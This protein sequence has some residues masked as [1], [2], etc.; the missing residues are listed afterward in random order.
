M[1]ILALPAIFILFVLISWKGEESLRPA[2]LLGAVMWGF[3]VTVMVESLSLFGLLTRVGVAA[4][5]WSVVAVSLLLLFTRS[6]G[7][8]PDSLHAAPWGV[9][10][11]RAWTGLLAGLGLV[12]VA[13]GITA[14]VA[15]PNN[16]DSMTYHMSRVVH[17]IQNQSVSHYPTDCVRQLILN[18][19]AE[20]AICLEQVLWGG[21]RFANMVQWFAMLGSLLGVTLIA[22]KLGGDRFDQLIAAVFCATIPMGILQ[23]SSTQ[24]DY[25]VSFW[26]VCFVYFGLVVCLNPEGRRYLISLL[27]TGVALGLAVLT[28][29]T[30]YLFG[31]PFALWF[32]YWMAKSRR[33]NCWKPLLTVAAIALLIN[34]GHYGRNI[35]T[36]GSPFS[37]VDFQESN[38]NQAWGVRYVISN[39]LRN[40]ALHLGTRS[41]QIN[42]ITTGAIEKVHVL[43]H[44]DASDRRTTF[45]RYSFSV[46]QMN[47][48][49]DGAG[50][51]IHL[52]IIVFTVGAFV[53]LGRKLSAPSLWYMAC[54]LGGMLLLCLLIKWNPWNSRYHLPFF[55]LASPLVGLVLKRS[56]GYKATVGVAIVLFICALPWVLFNKSRPLF[57]QDSIFV[58]SRPAQYFV[59]QPEARQPCEE[60]AR[61]VLSHE[62]SHVGLVFQGDAR[63]YVFW[64]LLGSV[65]GTGPN[66]RHLCV[67][68]ESKEIGKAEPYVGMPDCILTWG[69]SCKESTIGDPLILDKVFEPAGIR[70]LIPARNVDPDRTVPGPR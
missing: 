45:G 30:A 49:E 3:F 2:I 14:I 63:E 1:H 65:S 10:G 39:L 12:I 32:A 29:V 7:I 53:F 60:V 25:V 24:N 44:V 16:W 41:E 9:T 26:L 33:W 69:R 34:V 68:N 19:W 42:R 13:T 18:P 5:C 27:A 6:G 62:C 37:S 28:K 54:F 52:I 70:L 20:F 66:I 23:C 56:L 47:R 57:G 8:R 4:A 35:H 46:P 38:T 21:D 36:F 40:A 61:I 50:N 58:K 17:W 59:N 55:V 67:T 64:V 22:E 31:F 43:L 48:H 11:S 51:P 15:P